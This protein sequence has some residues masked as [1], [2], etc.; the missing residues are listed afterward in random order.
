[1]DRQGPHRSTLTAHEH[2]KQVSV[3]YVEADN[4]KAFQHHA[5]FL[6]GK[7][8][9]C[10]DYYFQI[11]YVSSQRVIDSRILHT[12]LPPT[13]HHIPASFEQ[14]DCSS[15]S[16][17][18]LQT[19]TFNQSQRQASPFLDL[20]PPFLNPRIGQYLPPFTCKRNFKNRSTYQQ[21]HT[22]VQ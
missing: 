14:Q 18:Y 9:K 1:M 4:P 15:E 11:I 13:M 19:Y 7:I 21:G 22:G 2:Q 10:H 3:N 5:F 6:L 20:L 12:T 16:S 17:T 8:E